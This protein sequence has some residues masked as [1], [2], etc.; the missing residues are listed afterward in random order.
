MGRHKE[1]DLNTLVCTKCGSD[2]IEQ[3]AWI[4]VNTNKFMEWEDEA[5]KN[6]YCPN[7]GLDTE[8]TTLREYR[9]RQEA[10]DEIQK[11]EDEIN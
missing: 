2:K 4:Q 11:D 3:R 7:C 8:L 6:C 5:D 9:D 1:A 10:I